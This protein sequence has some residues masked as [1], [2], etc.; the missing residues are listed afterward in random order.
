MLVKMDPKDLIASGGYGRIY[1]GR[2]MNESAPRVVAVKK[3]R[4]TRKV[5][6]MKNPMLRHEACA[7]LTLRGEFVS[8]PCTAM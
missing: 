8:S 7:M 4:I 3:A 5:A 1:A 6:V 2:V